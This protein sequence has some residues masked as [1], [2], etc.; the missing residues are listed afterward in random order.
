VFKDGLCVVK[1]SFSADQAGEFLSEEP[2]RAVHGT[3]YLF[4]IDRFDDRIRDVPRVFR[5][6]C[7]RV[8]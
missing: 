7:R 2:P 6:V 8:A 1:C 3:F 5:V 4:V